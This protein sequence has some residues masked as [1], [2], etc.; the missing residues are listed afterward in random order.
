M[1]TILLASEGGLESG[2]FWGK[3]IEQ[4]G[5]LCEGLVDEQLETDGGGGSAVDLVDGREDLLSFGL[6]DS[7]SCVGDNEYVGI[8]VE[9]DGGKEAVGEG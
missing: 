4:C 8:E 2:K 7:N 1:K 5:E 3:G 9:D 6:G